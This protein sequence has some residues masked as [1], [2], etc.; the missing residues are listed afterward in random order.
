MK[1]KCFMEKDIFLEIGNH[2]SK[3]SIEFIFLYATYD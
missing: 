3:L 2:D 1:L